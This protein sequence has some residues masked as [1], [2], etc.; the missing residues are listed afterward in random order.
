MT[1][2]STLSPPPTTDKITPYT[3]KDFL[4]IDTPGLFSEYL[5]HDELTKKYISEANV[6]VYTVDS[7]NP[8]KESH[9]PT[10]KWILSDL[11]KLESTIFVI[12]KI[13]EVAD[14]EDDKDFIKNAEI[15]KKVVSDIVHE[16]V[17]AEDELKI[18]C[19]SADPYGKGLEYWIKDENYRT[20]SRIDD[21]ESLISGFITK[22]RDE[23][24]TKAGVSVL[25]DTISQTL[26]ELKNLRENLNKELKIL[27]NQINEYSNRIEVLQESIL[28]SFLHIKEDILS[29]QDEILTNISAA[30]DKKELVDVILNQVGKDGYI[31]EEKINLIVMKHSQSISAESKKLLKSLD[32]SLEY[33]SKI[34][35]KLLKDATTVGKF[36]LKTL[37][38][39][40]P[41]KIADT[42]LKIRDFLKIPIKFRPWEALKV[43]RFLKGLP[44]VVEI[45]GVG[46]TIISHIQLEKKR[47]KIRNELQNVFKELLQSLTLESYTENYFPYVA[48]LISSL[49]M[50]KE[51]QKNINETI[52]AIDEISSQLSVDLVS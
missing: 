34:K 17:Q 37:L 13:D 9:L 42:I 20:L 30:K 5:K 26:S 16:I 38:G 6:I 43:A 14:L 4:I 40:Q 18:V 23:L 36:V 22:Y 28:R 25:Q 29:L 12:N 1:F 19:I 49:D 51:S 7:V 3:Y 21:L 46:F 32:E 8:L 24:V 45:L 50:L 52:S 47:T 41:R 2:G 33:H 35:D 48:E 31:L 11:K 39:A 15:K 27:S 44:I 10:L